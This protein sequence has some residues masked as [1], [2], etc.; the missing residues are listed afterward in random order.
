MW[1]GWIGSG[2]GQVRLNPIFCVYFRLGWVGF[3]VKKFWPV[4]APSFVVGQTFWPKPGPH[5][6][7]VGLCWIFFRAA[8]VGFIG[9]DV[10]R[11][12]AADMICFRQQTNR[13]YLSLE[14]ELEPRKI[15]PSLHIILLS[16]GA[17][18]SCIQNFR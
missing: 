9:L 11:N 14:S 3:G 7:R 1:L 17:S 4:H 12:G 15:M 18:I 6:D 13:V 5:I 10:T 8:Q 16:K 2:L